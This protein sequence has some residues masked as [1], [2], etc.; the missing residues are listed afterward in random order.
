MRR[1]PR[2]PDADIKEL[3]ELKRAGWAEKKI[4]EWLGCEPDQ[5][6]HYWQYY[7]GN[8]TAAPDYHLAAFRWLQQRLKDDLRREIELAK[9]EARSAN[10]P[11]PYRPTPA[12]MGY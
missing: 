2:L 12:Q 8:E 7:S 4:A 1:K 3:L 11:P 5:V 10:P 6:R 9:A